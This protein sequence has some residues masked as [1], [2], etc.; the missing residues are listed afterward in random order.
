[1]AEKRSADEIDDE[2]LDLNY[3]DQYGHTALW[4]TAYRNQEEAAKLLLGDQRVDPRI[5]FDQL[6]KCTSPDAQ[7]TI[8]L[9]K[10]FHRAHEAYIYISKAKKQ[11]DANDITRIINIC[12]D[13]PLDVVSRVCYRIYGL[14]YEL[15]NEFLIKHYQ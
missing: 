6:S 13:L 1:M 9:I 5:D 14:P 4:L 7:Q 2:V 15:V 8:E 11:T 3:K 10:N 12:K